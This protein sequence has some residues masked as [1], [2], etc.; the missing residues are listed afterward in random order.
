[1][2]TTHDDGDEGRVDDGN[3]HVIDVI[4]YL[5]FAKLYLDNHSY[6]DAESG[7]AFP[8]TELHV[9][10]F[11]RVLMSTLCGQAKVLA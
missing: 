6:G 9:G 11:C 3:P 8:R 7:R 1:M 4:F 10:E 5:R 2:M